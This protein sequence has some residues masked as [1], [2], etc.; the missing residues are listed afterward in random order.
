[1]VVA[2]ADRDAP[3][4][5]RRVPRA[6]TA[7]RRAAVREARECLAAVRAAP[8]RTRAAEGA[9]F[10]L[11][12]AAVLLPLLAVPADRPVPAVLEGLWAALLV[13]ARR[14]RPVAAV[15][16]SFTLI[17]THNVWAL[18]VLPVVVLS[19]AR[20]IT[21]AR[22]A[23]HAVLAACALGL[24]ESLLHGLSGPHPLLEQIAGDAVTAL[25]LV[26]LPALS[27]TLLG[28]RRPLVSLLRERNAYL[29]QARALT[30]ATARA[31]ERAR[32]AGEMHD[33]L[34]HRLSL[35]S[36]HA[37][38]LELAAARQA[39]P[40][41]ERAEL[42]RT[43][44][45]TAME[46]LREILDVLRRGETE[47]GAAEGTEAGRGT[48]EDVTALVAGARRAGVEAELHWSGPDTSD[49]G[50]RVR[51]A[52]HR[53]VRE[54]LTNVLKH[55]GGSRTSVRVAVT[56]GRTVVGVTSAMPPATS[57]PGGGNRSGLAGLEER[58]AVL[59]GTFTAGPAP[60][61]TFRVAAEL[62]S[63]AEGGHGTRGA[64]DA[65]GAHGVP[66][67]DGAHVAE[68]ALAGAAFSTAR[69]AADAVDVA[70]AHDA[71]AHDAGGAPSGARAPLSSEILTW[72]RLLGAGCTAAVV[73]LLSA[74]ALAA[75]LALTVMGYG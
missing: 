17:A 43:T 75:V 27:G 56:A 44:A 26:I 3:R 6:V 20:R 29:E 72:P 39:P 33:L 68:H 40:L 31:E 8:G 9:A 36:V 50:P 15:L 12:L 73:I 64:G 48:R 24:T 5:V 71:G 34:G 67:A 57:R 62:P 49:A 25:F 4:A 35:I 47:G 58:I 45:G 10:V 59:G 69:T 13:P 23:W 41:A 22:R 66:G 70:G 1:M 28:Q 30:G 55:A 11:A 19:A 14:H 2:G 74:G 21:P 42:L 37:G 46:E 61:G 65:L 52:L 54:A 51:Q 32:I 63:R 60:D 16:G 53:V 38:A 7:A 18:L